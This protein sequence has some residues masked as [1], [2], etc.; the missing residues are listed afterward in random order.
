MTERYLDYV[1]VREDYN[2]YEAENGQLLKSKVSVID[3]IEKDEAQGGESGNLGFRHVS[4]VYTTKPIDTSNLEEKEP[5]DVTEDNVVKELKFT[6][7]KESINIYESEKLI[8]LID[9]HVEKIFLTDKKDKKG[10]PILRYRV[11]MG[12]SVIP[13]QKQ[14]V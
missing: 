1:T 10:N 12:V 3:F 7:K 13:K 11:D 5:N 9:D 6:I 4:N 14:K 8:I 2:T